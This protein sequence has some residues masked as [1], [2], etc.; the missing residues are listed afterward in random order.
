MDWI[1]DLIF[2]EEDMLVV[3]FHTVSGGFHTVCEWWGSIPHCITTQTDLVLYSTAQSKPIVKINCGGGHRSY[4]ISSIQ[5]VCTV[6]SHVSVL[7]NGSQI[8]RTRTMNAVYVK[9]STLCF[10]TSSLES[11]FT[12]PIVQVWT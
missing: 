7:D 4:D 5:Q 3:G 1:E 6:L 10:R 8:L 9:Q 2:Q 11:Y 12:N